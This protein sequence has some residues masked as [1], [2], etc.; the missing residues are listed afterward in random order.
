VTAGHRETRVPARAQ[1]RASRGPSGQQAVRSREAEVS[2]R[3]KS[4]GLRTSSGSPQ[5]RFDEQQPRQ[6]SRDCSLRRG[7]VVPSSARGL[8]RDLPLL[9]H[10]H[11]RATADSLGMRGKQHAAEPRVSSM[12]RWAWSRGRETA[13]SGK[14]ITEGD[15]SGSWSVIACRRL[16][17]LPAWPGTLRVWDSIEICC[18]GSNGESP[19]WPR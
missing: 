9:S 7:A 6:R 2:P 1:L 19:A 10:G 4:L 18:N 15:G 8:G 14:S 16:S 3:R 12:Q 17:E 13:G 11:L 5:P